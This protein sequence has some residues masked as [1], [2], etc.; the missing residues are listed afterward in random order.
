M[1][2]DL[3][4][5]KGI[6]RTSLKKPAGG[7]KYL[8]TIAIDKYDGS[9]GYGALKCPVDNAGEIAKELENSYGFKV[10]CIKDQECTKEKIDDKIVDIIEEVGENGQ[11]IVFFTGHGATDSGS[12]YWIPVNS[13]D[14][15][16]K[17]CSVL[18]ILE[19]L[20]GGCA[21]VLLLID[22]CFSG[23]AIDA[24]FPIALFK[25]E[26]LQKSVFSVIT[27]GRNYEPVNDKSIFFE[28]LHNILRYSRV[29]TFNE[30]VAQLEL[31]YKHRGGKNKLTSYST[32]D[33]S[34]QNFLLQRNDCVSYELAR[35]LLEL[36]FSKQSPY[37]DGA[38]TFNMTYLRGSR[39]CG[40][41][42]FL[43][44]YFLRNDKDRFPNFN[45][46]VHKISFGGEGNSAS[47]SMWD[48]LAV[49][50]G[51]TN[52]APNVII[53]AL[54][55]ILHYNNFLLIARIKGSCVES[56]ME[57]ALRE[58]W[59]KLFSYADENEK[60]VGDY[61]HRI[62]FFIWD[63]RGNTDDIGNI[64]TEDGFEPLLSTS[65]ARLLALPAIGEVKKMDFDTWY[66]IVRKDYSGLK[67]DERF[68]VLKFDMLQPPRT[69]MNVIAQI[70]EV[71]G[72]RDAFSK[73]FAINKFSNND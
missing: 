56:E 16:K 69:V 5:T 53:Q 2:E 62:Y 12:G 42:I 10:E 17:N 11:L 6:D 32:V 21:Q 7:K 46:P 23:T 25:K 37:L 4:C 18:A 65:C 28:A 44:R 19:L 59:Q 38:T 27:A 58:F 15:V 41:D 20:V 55:N 70:E 48:Q 51:L 54:V 50:L 30:L 71:F 22:C 33:Q 39:N 43:H 3:D 64:I 45:Y 73:L 49:I 31:Q 24:A 68:R 52:P 8:L 63:V 72:R 40:H 61:A 67:Q 26:A 9:N 13:K 1:P 57:K 35:S 34:G 36:N 66:N 47:Y 60:V 29:N 14:N